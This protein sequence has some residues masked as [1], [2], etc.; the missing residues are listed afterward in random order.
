LVLWLFAL[1]VQWQAG[2]FQSEAS[3]T[4]ET[5]HI[6]TGLMAAD[7]VRTGWGEGPVEFAKT[8]YLHY[9]KVALGHW[10]PVFYAE[11]AVWTLLFPS[12]RSSLLVMIALQ[13]AVLGALL[14][15]WLHE[16]CG[17]VVAWSG[18]LA[19]AF[20]PGVAPQAASI[21]TEIPIAVLIL[22][23]LRSWARFLDTGEMRTAVAFGL[24]AALAILTKGT[25][26]VLAGV[27]LVSVWLAGRFDLLRRAAFWVPAAIVLILCA[28]W[29]AF[30][31]SAMHER[32][33]AGG[34]VAV[35][36]HHLDRLGALAKVAGKPLAMLA[37][38]GLVLIVLRRITGKYADGVS[39]STS[40]L[41]L[42]GCIFPIFVAVWESRHVA[43][44]MPATV[45]LA[46]TGL[47]WAIASLQIPRPKVWIAVVWLGVIAW[48]ISP[49]R[50]Q[51]AAGYRELAQR[52]VSGSFGPARTILVS[53]TSLM[54]G[55]LVSEIAQR[56]PH[57][58]RYIVRGGKLFADIEWMGRLVE[59]RATTASDA[60]KLV[61]G[62]PLDLVVVDKANPAPYG[63][64]EP[65]L[66]ALMNDPES[67][68]AVPATEPF[69][70]FRRVPA[71]PAI[72]S[73][74]VEA[75]LRAVLRSPVE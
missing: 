37:V 63:Y 30:A 15:P 52:I 62:L 7:Y 46:A 66:Q 55:V 29:Y 41:V 23:A 47:L 61:S 69:V 54:E 49:P 9:P 58:T 45:L 3:D 71:G 18:A 10:P 14:W 13:L 56:E 64:Q 74:E 59:L 60:H 25:G 48:S 34:G 72:S 35:S 17:T 31:P 5:A 38:A 68:Q 65:L 57:P 75:R 51:A 20:L 27:P 32:V 11:Q 53:G 70:L 6:V 2:A 24:W 43:E 73:D 19:L 1:L 4:D 22:L 33:I 28:P 44:I 40:A 39:A 67:W 36:S 42:S 26:V 21:M 16:R 8:Y 12:S 50:A